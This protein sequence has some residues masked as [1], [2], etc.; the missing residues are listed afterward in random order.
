MQSC[1]VNNSTRTNRNADNGYESATTG[2]RIVPRKRTAIIHRFSN[3]G[4]FSPISGRKVEYASISAFKE[5]GGFSVKH[6]YHP[7]L[8]NIQLSSVLYALSDPI[9]LFL[10]DAI[11]KSGETHCG[12][13][14][15]PIAKSTL[16]HHLKTLREAGVVRTRVQGT[17]R[18]MSIRTEDLEARFPGLL[19]SILSAYVSSGEKY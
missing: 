18:F 8:E 10:V 11:L 9:R 4:P 19:A 3:K 12:G 6:L 17:Q 13:V 14:D 2:P 1:I 15:V 7:E 16:S 5:R